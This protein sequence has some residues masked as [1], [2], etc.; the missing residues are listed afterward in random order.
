MLPG[1]SRNHLTIRS[2][3]SGHRIAGLF[4]DSPGNMVYMTESTSSIENIANAA[5]PYF[6]KITLQ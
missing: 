3:H 5:D 4:R 2:W 6:D 1:E